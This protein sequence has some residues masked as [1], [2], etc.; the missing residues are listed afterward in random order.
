MGM[1]QNIRKNLSWIL[2]PLIGLALL[3]FILMDSMGGSG[4]SMF[5]PSTDV[6]VI[7][8]QEI[9]VDEFSTT[10]NNAFGNSQGDRN[11]QISRVW[12]YFLD[13]NVVVEQAK[14]MGLEVCDAEMDDLMYGMNLSPIVQQVF[15]S[16]NTG[17]VDR[18][19][20]ESYR[21]A[22]E[23][24]ELGAQKNWW[25]HVKS[26]VYNEKLKEKLTNIAVKGMYVPTW[27][28]DMIGAQQQEQRDFVYV[29]VPFINV[30]DADVKITDADYMTYIKENAANL[31]SDEERRK[32]AYI[33]FDVVPSSS[34]T[35]AI[36]SK[37]V[38]AAAEFKNV[39]NDT[40]FVQTR[41]GIMETAYVKEDLLPAAI[42][43]TEEVIEKGAVYGPFTQ[44]NTFV[45]GKVLDK[46]LMADSV[47]ARHILIKVNTQ[48]ELIAA[49]QQLEDIKSRIENGESFAALAN[50]F[51]QD[52]SNVASQKGGDL[53]TVGFP[54]NFVKPFEDAI[55]FSIEEGG[56]EIV[57]TQF[58]LHLI[59]VT[60]K[61]YLNNEM[62]YKMA[63]INEAIVPS[64]ET[65]TAV[66][67]QAIAYTEDYN[68]LEEL[69][70]A[71]A[72]NP[73]L[74][75]ES[76]PAMASS[77]YIIPVLG[78]DQT[79]RDMVRW[80]Y[81]YDQLAGTDVY[82]GD[83]SPVL[84]TYTDPQTYAV[85]RYVVAS[86][87]SIVPEGLPKVEDV[88]NDI[89]LN[90]ANMVKGNYLAEKMNSM[91]L[92]KASSNYGVAVD[93]ASNVSLGAGF[94]ANLGAEPKVIATAF[95][96]DKNKVSKPIIGKGGVYILMPISDIR[97]GSAMAADVRRAQITQLQGQL[98]T[99][100]ISDL[101][102]GADVEY[103]LGRFY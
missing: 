4:V 11:A 31:S 44:S 71:I 14:D 18:Q 21:T 48:E 23:N 64:E 69:K 40:I 45:V 87:E 30:D 94:V 68:T 49:S 2:I 53:G 6:G 65:R 41:N 89:S 56:M 51:S 54:S 59:Q 95:A 83:V 61:Q 24:N 13:Q 32:I 85:T 33:S 3:A 46:M 62:G 43:N 82:V 70:E 73:S 29:K 38:A 20:L 12:D 55:F 52:D 63:Y 15:R 25:K 102:S 79:S 84:Y 22:E 27:Q 88:K 100:L 86:L 76:T 72:S 39:A 97:E 17:Q 42:K 5:A 16:P 1:I 81:G 9:P 34:D 28:A 67:D 50:E 47:S 7:N 36:R 57:G 77:D 78:A 60:D 8:G 93:T 103:Q 66:E 37:M 58:G 90:V 96:T 80:A 19:I 10:L 35:A 75:L 99:S 101:K 92:S 74:K 91:D 98:R 26:L